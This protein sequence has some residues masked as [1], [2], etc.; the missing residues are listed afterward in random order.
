MNVFRLVLCLAGLA[1]YFLVR[2]SLP[3]PAPP[4]PT[5]A[6]STASESQRVVVPGAPA[7]AT[8]PN[9]SHAPAG[10]MAARR[11]AR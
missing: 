5:P 3:F 10:E 9:G 4:T 8:P 1:I 11:L 6:R 2:Y 7:Q